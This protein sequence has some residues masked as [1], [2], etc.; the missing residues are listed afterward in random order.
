MTT[1]SSVGNFSTKSERDQRSPSAEMSEELL[2]HRWKNLLAWLD[3]HG[4]KAQDLPVECRQSAAAG[5]G[6]FARKDCSPATTLFSIP[7]SAMM[8]KMSLKQLYSPQARVTKALTAVQLISMHLLLWRPKA[9]EGCTDAHFGPYISTLPRN[10][11][12]HPL[13][14]LVQSKLGGDTTS[15]TN[16][17]ILLERLPQSVSVALQQLYMRFWEDW[18]KVQTFMRSPSMKTTLEDAP[19]G[20]QAASKVMDFLWAWLNVNTR[21]IYYRLKPLKNDPD[22]LTMCP[23]LDFANHTLDKPHITP[24]PSNADIWN[25]APVKSIGDGFKFLSPDNATI[26]E[27]DEIYL[28]YGSHSNKTLFVEYGFVNDIPKDIPRITG[29]VDVQDILEEIVSENPR[30]GGVVK[31]VLVTEGYW[32]NWVLHSTKDSAQPSWRLITALRLHHLVVGAGTAEDDT[33][34][35]WRDVIAG[36]RERISDDNE[37]LWRGTVVHLCDVVVS[38]AEQNLR[39]SSGGF[40]S[41]QDTWVPWMHENIRTLWR[42]ELLVARAVKESV[43]RGDEF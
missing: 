6:L 37:Q 25:A 39:S 36:K 12:S 32:G 1:T 9:D 41:G 15:A 8:N 20:L 13:T 42:E 21:C 11:E 16:R 38:R 7:A 26:R 43:L 40:A 31:D 30:L 3:G 24:V 14:W 27:G 5:N 35:V 28:T 33:I 29:E 22:N 2:E 10:F 18:N 17:S 19:N 4:F 34:Q 23:I